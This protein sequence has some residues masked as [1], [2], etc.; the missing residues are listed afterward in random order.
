MAEL[1]LGAKVTPFLTF[2][3]RAEEAMQLYVSLFDPAEVIRIQRYGADAGDREGSVMLASFTL[4]GQQFRCSDSPPVHDWGFTP[5]ISLF[6]R[7]DSQAE[8]ERLYR[9]LSE[10]GQVFMELGAYPFAAQ[11]AWVGDRFGVT[12]QLMFEG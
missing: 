7:C 8:I 1:G 10:G 2:T 11:F 9:R 4:A 3:G 6:V 12:W 5:A